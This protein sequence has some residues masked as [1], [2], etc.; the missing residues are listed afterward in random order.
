[1]YWGI[2]GNQS[3]SS[4]QKG[5][6]LVEA[7]IAA[8][9]MAFTISIGSYLIVQSHKSS[10]GLVGAS[11]CKVR[12]ELLIQNFAN[13]ANKTN[14][15]N[16][17]YIGGTQYPSGSQVVHPELGLVVGGTPSN[18]VS[19]YYNQLSSSPMGGLAL[20]S[21][22]QTNGW[23]LIDASPNWALYLASKYPTFCNVSSA[24]VGP[25]NYGQ[26]VGGATV[27]AFPSGTPPSFASGGL[28]PPQGVAPNV[29]SNEIDYLNIRMVSS[30]GV[31]G[32][33]GLVPPS[34]GTPFP[35]T[36]VPSG[37]NSAGFNN[38]SNMSIEVVGSVAY[39]AP[40]SPSATPTNFCQSSTKIKLDSDNSPPKFISPLPPLPNSIVPSTAFCGAPGTNNL[41]CLT[42]SGGFATPNPLATPSQPTSCAPTLAGG[43]SLSFQV[44]EPGTVFG[45][46]L[47]WSATTPPPPPGSPNLLYV[48]GSPLTANGVALTTTVTP[49]G[50]SVPGSYVNGSGETITISSGAT[51]MPEGYYQ[52]WVR[53][54]D[55]AQNTSDQWL[56]FQVSQ[57][58]GGPITIVPPSPQ[59]AGF[60]AFAVATRNHLPVL[61]PYTFS[62]PGEVFECSD[63][64]PGDLWTLAPGGS[65]P[66]VIPPTAIWSYTATS[67]G[68][69]T[70]LTPGCQPNV[71]T[72][73]ALAD[74]SYTMNVTACNPCGQPIVGATPQTVPWIVDRVAGPTPV[75]SPTS[76]P[77]NNFSASPTWAFA[78]AKPAP[79]PYE[80][81]C[82]NVL[83]FS[84]TASPT[85]C[86]PTG[87]TITANPPNL[88][89]C[90]SQGSYGFCSAAVDGCGRLNPDVNTAYQILASQGESCCNVPCK[91][92]LTCAMDLSALRG[93]CVL[94]VACALDSDCAGSGTCY[95]AQSLCYGAGAGPA[96][97]TCGAV[98]TP[99]PLPTPVPTVSVV[100]T[101]VPTPT[102]VPACLPNGTA[103]NTFACDD[104]AHSGSCI[105]SIPADTCTTT[106]CAAAEYGD[107][108]YSKS[109]GGKYGATYYSYTNNNY[110]GCAP[111]GEPVGTYSWTSGTLDSGHD[112][113]AGTCCP[114]LTP[115]AG[116]VNTGGGS[117]PG[118]IC[119]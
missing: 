63:T 22:N 111:S 52:L 109:N 13:N 80:Y 110:C 67:T 24:E 6:S 12:S 53:A 1:M 82:Q 117:K 55:S 69:T 75:H 48:C 105:Y 100:S 70:V 113:Y 46:A 32:C 19:P 49:Y 58:N 35:T 71:L 77:T 54:F 99:I 91:A 94:P 89:P 97:Q 41:I 45:C 88:D 98:P 15:S 36:L 79:L 3:T 68:T 92:G 17:V 5:M 23:E 81:S 60:N 66:P 21:P 95:K 64:L 38:G 25:T 51:P 29:L 84:L 8:A 57:F 42:S 102:P 107:D 85:S 90:T 93:T 11:L 59:I 108:A 30:A 33:P 26:A 14:I 31:Y 9:I 56:N 74:G 72:P 10:S 27:P 47:S 20:I 101:P 78:G 103:C 65:P 62:F 116:T 7:M 18:I 76:T 44:N 73:T 4:Y 83:P 43:Y 96:P 28:A 61:A 115:T 86:G 118:L 114:G 34:G 119:K 39:T 16:W 40:N 37:P 2:M 106:C 87:F 104:Y 112:T 50:L